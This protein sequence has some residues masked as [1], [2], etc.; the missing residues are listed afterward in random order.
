M[1]NRIIRLQVLL[2]I[3][4]NHSTLTIDLLKAQSRQ[5]RTMIYQKR[6]VLDYLLAEEGGAC[7]KFNSSEYCM[8]IDDHCEVITN[9]TANFRKLSHVPKGLI[10]PQRESLI[11]RE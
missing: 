1:L 4:S 10:K 6:L 9:I 8:E 7:G 2:E 5:M 11:T 3:I